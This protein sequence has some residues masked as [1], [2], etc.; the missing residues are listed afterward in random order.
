M[1]A[2]RN[3]VATHCEAGVRHAGISGSCRILNERKFVRSAVR[4]DRLQGD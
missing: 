1:A 2:V 4:L 3:Q